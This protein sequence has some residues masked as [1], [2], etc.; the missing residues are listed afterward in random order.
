M[1]QELDGIRARSVFEGL[2]INTYT[3]NVSKVIRTLKK[4]KEGWQQKELAGRC[5]TAQDDKMPREGFT[6]NVTF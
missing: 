3:H 5:D 2:T 4:N 1:C 6:D